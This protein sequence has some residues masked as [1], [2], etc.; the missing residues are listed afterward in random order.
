[1]SIL[2][3]QLNENISFNAIITH[4]LQKLSEA[5]VSKEKERRKI[6]DD[7]LRVDYLIIVLF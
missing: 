4:E 1:M 5:E 6:E 3:N 7:F 2:K